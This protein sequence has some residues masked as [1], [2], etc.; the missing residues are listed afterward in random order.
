MSTI[1]CAV[2]I[3][4]SINGARCTAC[5]AS[6]DEIAHL[7]CRSRGT[8][9]RRLESLRTVPGLANVV[10]PLFKGGWVARKKPNK[11]TRQQSPKLSMSLLRKATVAF[12]VSITKTDE[13][14]IIG[15][16]FVVDPSGVIVTAKHVVADVQDAVK[17]LRS[18]KRAARGE[19]LAYLGLEKRGGGAVGIN[20]A[21]ISPSRDH[22]V[23]E[24]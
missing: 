20:Y 1:R 10:A 9:R 11:T 21:R 6:E 22:G 15:T 16:G 14:Q 18:K 13:F 3:I 8:L 19:V 7:L 5:F 4:A 2:Q 17:K 24:G 23:T 12:G